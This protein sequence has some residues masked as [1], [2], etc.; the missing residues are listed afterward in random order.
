MRYSIVIVTSFK[1]AKL[2]LKLFYYSL[3]RGGDMFNGFQYGRGR[4]LADGSRNSILYEWAQ[5]LTGWPTGQPIGQWVDLFTKPNP[6]TNRL[7]G[8]PRT[9]LANA[10]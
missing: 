7:T 9:P 4:F 1:I 2:I 5:K 6:L 3:C 8:W 10:L